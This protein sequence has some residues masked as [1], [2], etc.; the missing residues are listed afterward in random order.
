[1]F[2]PKTDAFDINVLLDAEEVIFDTDGV[3]LDWV[4]PFAPWASS[5]LKRPLDPT[6]I[7]EFNLTS[8]LGVDSTAEMVEMV[9]L[10]NGSAEHGFDRLPPMPGAVGLV[11]MLHDRGTRMRVVTSCSDD[12]LVKDLR[13]G[14]L[15]RTFGNVF[16]DIV[17]LG[18]GADK[19]EALSRFDPALWIDD[20]WPNL[21]AGA[22]AGHTPVLMNAS[23]NQVRRDGGRDDYPRITDWRHLMATVQPA[24]LTASM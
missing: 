21:D 3:L 12:P 8:W 24:G 9:T 16:Q 6:K 15:V 18:L 23:Y 11:Q 22:A 1:M 20:H 17:V 4:S 7:T 19:T 13:V 5:R 10:F 2:M 14:N